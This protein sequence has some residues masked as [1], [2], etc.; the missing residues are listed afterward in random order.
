[1]LAAD[2]P[3]IFS[4]EYGAFLPNVPEDQLFIVTWS[5][6]TPLVDKIKVDLI[7]LGRWDRQSVL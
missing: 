6:L 3:F 1:M 7:S 5:W 4:K 2:V